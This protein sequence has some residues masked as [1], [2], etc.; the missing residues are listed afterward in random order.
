MSALVL[1]MPFMRIPECF[2]KVN[3]VVTRIRLSLHF[4]AHGISQFG[5]SLS[6]IKTS[7]YCMTVDESYAT[8]PWNNWYPNDVLRSLN[9]E[10]G[11]KLMAF[12]K[13]MLWKSTRRF[14]LS[15]LFLSAFVQDPIVRMEATLTSVL[16][17]KCAVLAV[18]SKVRNLQN[19]HRIQPLTIRIHYHALVCCISYGKNILG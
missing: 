9:F 11:W 18:L 6:D 7:L 12:W 17:L 5:R 8:K 10:S 13:T 14:E 16:T 4:F 3:R 2:F 19:G 1:S 15:Y